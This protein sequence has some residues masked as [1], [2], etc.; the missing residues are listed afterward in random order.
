V[1]LRGID[2]LLLELRSQPVC[3]GQRR[4]TLHVESQEW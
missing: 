2:A 1:H 3:I 4:R